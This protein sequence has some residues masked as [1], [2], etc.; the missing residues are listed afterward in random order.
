[1]D[2]NVKAQ[3]RLKPRREKLHLLRLR[4]VADAGKA[5]FETLLVV[6]DRARAL[7]GGEFAEG[8]R[9]QGGGKAQMEELGEAPPGRCSFVGLD[10]DVPELGCVF[11]VVGGHPQLFLLHDALLVE[12]RFA[13]VDEDEG[14]RLAVELGEIQFLES[15]CV[16]ARAG[17][18]TRGGIGGGAVEAVDAGLDAGDLL[19]D[20]LDLGIHLLL[21]AIDLDVQG[22]VEVADEVG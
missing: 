9:A 16:R 1:V 2:L 8:I 4:E 7:A 6:H 21:D 13:P 22:S 17:D 5:S 19:L 10:L 12:V 18:R 3:Q 20:A 11:Q 14:V 15:I